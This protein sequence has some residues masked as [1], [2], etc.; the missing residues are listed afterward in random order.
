MPSYKY[1]YAFSH[2]DLFQNH[3][4]V[5]EFEQTEDI[6]KNVDVFLTRLIFDQFTIKKMFILFP[7]REFIQCLHVKLQSAVHVSFMTFVIALIN[8]NV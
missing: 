4:T 1:P 2:L 6:F 5:K 3:K 7:K 8:T